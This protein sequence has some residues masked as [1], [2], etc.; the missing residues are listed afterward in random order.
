MSHVH[1][2]LAKNSNI[3]AVKINELFYLFPNMGSAD[4]LFY[5]PDTTNTQKSPK[6]INNGDLFLLAYLHSYATALLYIFGLNLP[7][8]YKLLVPTAALGVA[9]I[10]VQRI[11]Y[12]AHV[13]RIKFLVLYLCNIAVYLPI[14]YFFLRNPATSGMLW[15]WINLVLSIVNLV[16]QI[17][18]IQQTKSVNGFS[19][20]F[21]LLSAL[22]G[23]CELIS[24]GLLNLPLQSSLMG[25]KNIFFF[26]I[27]SIQFLL[28]RDA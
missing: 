13:H 2:D 20:S 11:I 5:L 4:L 1:A 22:G 23:I 9:M 26:L 27:F 3:V 6:K 14:I 25:M 10:I 18:T 8:A 15:G 19:Y 28:Y 16:P 17:I 12:E 21:V 7:M 24:A